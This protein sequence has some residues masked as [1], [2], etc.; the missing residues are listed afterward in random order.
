[1]EVEGQGGRAPGPAGG[2]PEGPSQT[3][4]RRAPPGWRGEPAAL[5]ERR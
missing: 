1:M 2:S 5:R 4:T 3:Q